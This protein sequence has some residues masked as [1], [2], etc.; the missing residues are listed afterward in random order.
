MDYNGNSAEEEVLSDFD[1]SSDASME[2]SSS[3]SD[4]SSES[5]YDT[6]DEP[7]LSWCW[8]V[9]VDEAADR[10]EKERQEIIERLVSESGETKASAIQIANAKILP[11]VTKEIRK[12]LVEKLEWIQLMKKD[13]NFQKIIKTKKELLETGDYDWLEAIKLAVHNRKYLL[14]DLIPQ[15]LQN[16]YNAEGSTSDDAME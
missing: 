5:E 1:S 11:M 10:H 2:S 6:D 12:A 9:L 3:D 15:Y 7:D 16:T 4:V 14:N 8:Q 13:P